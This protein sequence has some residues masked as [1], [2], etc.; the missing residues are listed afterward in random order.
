MVPA[1][2]V[3]FADWLMCMCMGISIEDRLLVCPHVWTHASV[4]NWQVDYLNL[5]FASG[6]VLYGL[7]LCPRDPFLMC[8][9]DPVTG[10]AYA[11]T[12]LLDYPYLLM[13]AVCLHYR[14]QPG[15]LNALLP[16]DSV[17]PCMIVAD[18]CLFL[19]QILCTYQCYHSTSPVV[20]LLIRYQC[21]QVT[22]Y[23]DYTLAF[24]PFFDPYSPCLIIQGCSY[25]NCSRDHHHHLRLWIHACDNCGG[26]EPQIH[27]HNLTPTTFNLFWRCGSNLGTCLHVWWTCLNLQPFWSEVYRIIS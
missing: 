25:W 18:L 27:I 7:Q 15:L 8:I 10:P 3:G 19:T 21:S 13:F 20:P 23:S 5:N 1:S 16:S 14:L 6:L 11:L 26:I 4:H 24:V 17:P 9:H 22:A 12:L 2:W